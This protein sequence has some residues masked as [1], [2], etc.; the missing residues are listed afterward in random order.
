MIP[1]TAQFACVVLLLRA[2]GLLF[3]KYQ[4]FLKRTAIAIGCVSEGDGSNFARIT[5]ATCLQMLGDLM[6]RNWSLSVAT[7]VSTDDFGSSHLDVR[8]HMRG[9]DV[10]DDLGGVSSLTIP[11]FEASHSGVPLF[12]IFSNA[13]DALCPASKEKI[14]K[15]PNDG[16]SNVT[17]R[18]VNGESNWIHHVPFRRFHWHK[19]LS[20]VVPSARTRYPCEGQAAL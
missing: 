20:H 12:T 13:F 5:Y 16:A 11:L 2:A 1:N 8:T 10:A 19:F 17:G 3:A 6:P 9:I 15:P 18:K 14:V 7:D 4:K